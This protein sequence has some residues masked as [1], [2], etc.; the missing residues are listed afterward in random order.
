MYD[1]YKLRRKFISSIEKGF[2]WFTVV[3]LWESQVSPFLLPFAC[4]FTPISRNSLRPEDMADDIRFQEYLF[5]SVQ[6]MQYIAWPYAYSK[7]PVPVRT[8]LPFRKR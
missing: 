1:R 3:F 2:A 8:I 7:T 4:Q 6:G 5:F